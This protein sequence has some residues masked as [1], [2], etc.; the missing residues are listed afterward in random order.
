MFVFSNGISFIV[1]INICNLLLSILFEMC[2]SNGL[3]SESVF[4]LFLLD[5]ILGSTISAVLY[6]TD[7]HARREMPMRGNYSINKTAYQKVRSIG[8]GL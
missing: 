5:N 7:F 1:H 3:T 8:S 6:P 4:V 2:I